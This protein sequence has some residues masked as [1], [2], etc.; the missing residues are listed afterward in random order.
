MARIRLIEERLTHS[1]IG[2]FFDVYNTLGYGFLEHLYVRAMEEELH[3]RGHRVAREVSVRVMYN[4]IL[5]G[6]QRLD[7]I[8]DDK[9]VVEA[10]ASSELHK[11][12]SRQ[13]YNY[14][15]ATNLKLGLL[16]HFGPEPTF[17]R[18]ICPIKKQIRQKRSEH[19]PESEAS[20]FKDPKHQPG[21][22]ASVL[23]AVMQRRDSRRTRPRAFIVLEEHV[24][25]LPAL[26]RHAL[27]PLD[28]RGFIVVETM[29]PQIAP[30]RGGHDRTLELVLLDDAHRDVPLAHRVVDLVVEPA[31]VP[32]LEHV[33]P[34]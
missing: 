1:V 13:L 33:P 31:L 17:H 29:Q 7:L 16:L 32:E 27:R 15:R 9:I 28:E 8:V 5:L 26:P 11:S 18:I 23:Q 21:S 24:R 4:G 2:A 30:R 34:I 12:A 3:A 25:V 14:L 6:L 22:E 20:V 19:Q 10:K